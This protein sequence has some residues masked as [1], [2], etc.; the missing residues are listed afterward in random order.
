M[1]S[2][3]NSLRRVSQ[4]PGFARRDPAELF[5]R[6]IMTK[7][8]VTL[9]PHQTVQDAAQILVKRHLS[10]APVVNLAGELVGI[11]SELDCLGVVASGEYDQEDAAQVRRVEDLMTRDV[12]VVQSNTGIYVIVDRFMSLRVQRLPVV[13][14]G[15]LVGL[16]TRRD[17]LHGIERLATKRTEE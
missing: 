12:H 1:A 4:F 2:L 17:V 5:A 14:D 10:G 15:K 13:D 16:V 7:K 3:A 6:D 8:L 9:K 11:L